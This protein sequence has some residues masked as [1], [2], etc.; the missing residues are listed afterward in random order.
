VNA[1][2]CDMGE[3]LEFRRRPVPGGRAGSAPDRSEPAATATAAVPDWQGIMTV[4]AASVTGW[5][6]ADSFDVGDD[7]KV[8]DRGR[9]YPAVVLGIDAQTVTVQIV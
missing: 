7:I 4:H 2:G 3:I 8:T 6:N 5:Q 9:T 1:D